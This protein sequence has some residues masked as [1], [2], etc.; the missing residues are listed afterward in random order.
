MAARHSAG[1]S[2]VAKRSDRLRFVVPAS[3]AGRPLDRA[4]Q[5][6]AGR[7]WG[8]ARGLMERGKILVAR[9]RVTDLEWRVSEGD[10]VEVEP[11]ATRTVVSGLDRAA[12]LYVDPHL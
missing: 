3:L 9:E 7:T 10:I 8:D 4:V 6:L 1:R 5:T 2:S 11:R 12:L